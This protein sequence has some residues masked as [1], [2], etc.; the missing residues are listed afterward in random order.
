[1]MAGTLLARDL[2]LAPTEWRGQPAWALE[3]ARLRVVTREIAPLGDLL[4]Y[5]ADEPGRAA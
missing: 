5:V 4:E 3:S 1:M 2:I